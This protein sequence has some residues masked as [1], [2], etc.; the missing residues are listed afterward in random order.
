[1]F[2]N[3]TDSP[4]LTNTR[5]KC[6]MIRVKRSAEKVKK[7]VVEGL[8]DY[9]KMHSRYICFLHFLSRW[10]KSF[11]QN[12]ASGKL[13]VCSL[14]QLLLWSANKFW[15]KTIMRSY[16]NGYNHFYERPTEWTFSSQPVRE[17]TLDWSKIPRQYTYS[18]S[19]HLFSNLTGVD[20]MTL[21]VTMVSVAVMPEKWPLSARKTPQIWPQWL[22][23]WRLDVIDVHLS[24]HNQ[25]EV[26]ANADL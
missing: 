23:V 9:V 13:Q 12:S 7:K 15:S 20:G 1:M 8:G 25:D 18:P 24:T 6:I 11:H 21:L 5:G 22:W 14:D 2:S 3:A 16:Y 19:F 4:L 26:F 17:M 10:A